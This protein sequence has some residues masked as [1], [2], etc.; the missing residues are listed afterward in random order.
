M[1]ILSNPYPDIS[2]VIPIYNEASGIDT[3]I[4]R[5]IHALSRISESFELICVDD[6]STDNGLT[7]L[8]HW[9]E[10]DDRIKI[11]VLS[12]NFGHPAAYTAGMTHAKGKYIAL[13]DGD[14]QDPPELLPEMYEQLRN[15][16]LDIVH[17]K[18]QTRAE[19][20]PKRLLI[21]GFHAI[22]K[23]FAR[24]HY[25]DNVGNFSIFNR[26]VLNAI[27]ALPETHRYLPG[28]R[29]WVGFRQGFFSYQRAEREEGT[30][31]M[32][33]AQLFRLAFDAIFSFSDFPIKMCLYTGLFGI[34]TGILGFAYSVISK[35]LGV[36]PL[37]WSST[38]FSI[39][40]F[41]SVQLVFLGV[42]GEYVYRIYK[43][44]QKRPLFIVR[45]FIE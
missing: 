21:H 8:T 26:K 5:S 25:P 29:I 35:C 16:P 40:F 31:K 28:L 13:M 3:L 42:L 36:A 45:E 7:N 34:I 14:L 37:G 32:S 15:N 11:V 22:F 24:I 23:R 33:T 44:I 19:S 12:R 9:H 10:Q 41:G 6:G 39:Y 27:L 2:L 30:P 18:R 4:T 1:P 20:L 43:E 38:V 17:G